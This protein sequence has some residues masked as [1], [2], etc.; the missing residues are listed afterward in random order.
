MKKYLGLGIVALLVLF[1]ASAW[2]YP[3]MDG[4]SG[5]VTLPTAEVTPTGAL[6]LAADYTVIDWWGDLCPIGDTTMYPV[7]LNAGVAKNLELSG[8]YTFQHDDLDVLRRT[9]SVG[10]KYAFLTEN[11]DKVGLAL[12]GSWGKIEDKYSDDDIAL[13][14]VALALTKGFPVDPQ[15]KAKA[16]VG[17][18]YCNAGDWLDKSYTKP[19]IGL[20]LIGPRGANLALEYRWKGPSPL[21]EKD[22]FSAV[23]RLPLMSE[24]NS[25]L[26]L[27]VGT[28]NGAL[29]G[30]ESQKFFGGICYRFMTK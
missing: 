14:R 9:W 20:E 15:F 27:Q 7:R 10:A 28:S 12:S 1:A 23:V 6:D 5:L 3:T 26:W 18:A 13:T 21:E 16:T 2:A 29:M 4:V 24:E 17:V 11:K 25:P 30:F 22:V 8:N 19:Y